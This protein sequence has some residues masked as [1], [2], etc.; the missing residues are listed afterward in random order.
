MNK[1]VEKKSKKE[2]EGYSV[3]KIVDDFRLCRTHYEKE[4]K[5]MKLLNAADNGDIWKALKAKYPKY[6]I[7]AD[8]NFVSYVKNN[9]L[10]SIYTV[11][12]G[13]SIQP[14][15]EH[16]KEV[17]MNLNIVLEYIWDMCDVGFYQFMA[18]ER[19]ALTNM[20][21]TQIGWDEKLTAGNADSFY[22]GNI[23]LKN[24]DP[25]KFMM[26]PFADSLDTAG[27]CMTY[28]KYHKSVLEQNPLYKDKF[29]E[30]CK[31]QNSSPTDMPDLANDRRSSASKDYYTLLIYFR[32]H[33]GKVEEYH[34][35]NENFILYKN[36]DI[37]PSEFP[38]AVLYCNLPGSN[39]IGASEPAKIFT[40]YVALN[41]LDSLTLTA[42]YKNQNPP[43]YVNASSGLNI[44]AFAKHCDEPNRAFIVNGQTDKVVYYHKYPD[45]PAMLSNLKSQLEMGMQNMSGVDGRY[46]GRDT[47]SVITTGGVE[48]MLNRVTIIDT[49]K[50]TMYERY[51][52]QLTRL[53]LSNL[54]EFAPKRKYFI[55]QPNTTEY[56]SYEIDFP[57]IDSKTL[58]DYVINIS[59]E[60]PK[61]KQRI[62]AMANMLLEKQ[63]QYQQEGSNVQLISEEEWLMFQDIPN[64]EYMLKRMGIQRHEDALEEVAQTLFGYNELI[65][66]GASPDDAMLAMA[67]ALRQK[68]SGG[69]QQPEIPGVIPEQSMI[70]PQGGAPAA[71]PDMGAMMQ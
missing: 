18:G 46:T 5:R 47:G 57:K 51:T 44:G 26:D 48:E 58:F 16:D 55:K 3:S 61:N 56:K 30:F 45:P 53:I 59:S 69:L 27:Y 42:L 28:D 11:A 6:Q 54:I 25:M 70:P 64:K 31:T 52:K 12:R 43:K 63:M 1:E 49:P 23:T 60:L 2:Y 65:Q 34:I 15:T 37:K 24:I 35:I 41:L 40:N 8:T 29:K 71:M 50:I 20:G 39:L 17:V 66:N 38:F 33:K 62:A 4:H 68:R 21:V 9:I 67:E 13:A 10:A 36:L 22:K 14:T 19:A 7:F 32:R